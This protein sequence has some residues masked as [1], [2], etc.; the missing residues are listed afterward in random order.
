MVFGIYP[1]D[2]RYVH[3]LQRFSHN[4]LRLSCPEQ[5]GS[6]A[7]RCYGHGTVL[8]TRNGVGGRGFVQ[9]PLAF[10][11]RRSQRILINST[12]L[13]FGPPRRGSRQRRRERISCSEQVFGKKE[14]P[15]ASD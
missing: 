12:Y 6:G 8:E 10:L 9:G 3:L 13:I 15:N 5:P 2:N 11:R 4:G 7:F 14:G 1:F